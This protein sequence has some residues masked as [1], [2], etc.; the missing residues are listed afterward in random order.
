MRTLA[1]LAFPAAVT[2]FAAGWRSHLGDPPSPLRPGATPVIVELFTSEGCSDCPPAD[3]YLATLDRTQPVEGVSVIGLEEHVDYWNDLGWADPFSAPGFN[4]RQGFYTTALRL[5]VYTP[6][7]VVDGRTVLDRKDPKAA[8][9][10]Q[11]SAATPRAL[12]AVTRQGTRF[13]V[14][15]QGVPPT[16]DPHRP[17]EVWLAVAESGLDSEVRSGENAGRRLAHAPVARTTRLL[18]LAES[19]AFRLEGPIDAS[20]FWRPRAL[21]VVVFVQD[22][23]SRRILGAGAS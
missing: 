8:R 10:L 4:L 7:L 11:A 1:L 9:I 13:T 19:G 18:G 12:V 22:P 2:A 15:I 6:L 16:A 14:E 21:R 23:T 5:G 20:L 17:A 3:A